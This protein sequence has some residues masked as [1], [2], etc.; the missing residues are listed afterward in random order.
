M[1]EDTTGTIVLPANSADSLAEGPATKSGIGRFF[2][3]APTAPT[4]RLPGGH[5]AYTRP[6][7]SHGSTGSACATSNISTLRCNT[8]RNRRIR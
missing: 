7:P 8:E 2:E 6:C 4:G 5:R 1:K 3:F